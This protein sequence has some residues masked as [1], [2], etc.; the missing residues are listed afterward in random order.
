MV[1]SGVRK[2]G[3]DFKTIA[4]VL[5]TKT[6]SHVRSY[7]VNYKRRYNLDGAYKEYEEEFGP[8]GDEEVKQNLKPKIGF[9]LSL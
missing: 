8:T 9:F 4:E 1:F 2:F 7:Y 5:G 3:K 6:E